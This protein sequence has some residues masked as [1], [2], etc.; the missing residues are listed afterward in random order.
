[1]IHMTLVDE[2]IINLDKEAKNK[3]LKEIKCPP[4]MPKEEWI[5]MMLKKY[6]WRTRESFEYSL[7]KWS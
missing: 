5:Q 7:I 4:P 6:P 1:M 3:K 2:K